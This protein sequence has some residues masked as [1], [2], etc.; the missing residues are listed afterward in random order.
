MDTVIL[1]VLYVVLTFFTIIVWTLLSIV[2]YKLSKVLNV[3]MEMVEVYNKFKQI[4]SI[5]NQI[6]EM[7]LAKAKEMIFWK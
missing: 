4:I 7:I 1:N 3:V 5:Y 6:P 2:L